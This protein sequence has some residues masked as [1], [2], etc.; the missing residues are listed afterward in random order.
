MR[1]L[2]ERLAAEEQRQVNRLLNRVL[3][4]YALLIV[5]GLGLAVVKMPDTGIAQ[6]RAAGAVAQ[7]LPAPAAR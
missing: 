1:H 5:A 4:V 6:A 2:H 7:A 3:A